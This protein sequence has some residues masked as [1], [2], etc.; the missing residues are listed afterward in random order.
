M[1]AA[2]AKT[3]SALVVFTWTNDR[4]WSRS[5]GIRGNRYK[6]MFPK[7]GKQKQMGSKCSWPMFGI[8]WH[9]YISRSRFRATA[10]EP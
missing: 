7:A 6:K 4:K 9:L 1:G 8:M 10:F 3:L 2:P 5:Q